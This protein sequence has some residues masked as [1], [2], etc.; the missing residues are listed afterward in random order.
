MPKH[1]SHKH[2]LFPCGSNSRGVL[3]CER[4]S[5]LL[6][7]FSLGAASGQSVVLYLRGGDRITGTI[8]SESTNR[9]VLSTKWAKEVV[10]PAG[11]ILKR[12]AAPAPTEAKSGGV[13]PVGPAIGA[14][15]NA[16]PRPGTAAVSGPL[17][18]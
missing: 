12:E 16:A 9:V 7:L 2:Q 18:Q 8:V 3:R 5:L 4:L 14:L 13:K 15:T 11:E 6:W 1:P 10:V 17:P